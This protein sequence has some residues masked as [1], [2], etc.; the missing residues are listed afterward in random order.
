VQRADKVLKAR[1]ELQERIKSIRNLVS[2]TTKSANERS[3][4]A[5]VEQ[6][7]AKHSISP[8]RRSLSPQQSPQERH[9]SIPPEPPQ[10][11]NM[12]HVDDRPISLPSEYIKARA[13]VSAA[14]SRLPGP[15]EHATADA[16]PRTPTT[17]DVTPHTPTTGID[18]YDQFP[19]FVPRYGELTRLTC[20]SRCAW[21]SLD[22]AL[23]AI[24]NMSINNF[25]S[26]GMV[27]PEKSEIE[28]EVVGTEGFKEKLWR[29]K[30]QKE[31]LKARFFLDSFPPLDLVDVLAGPS[32]RRS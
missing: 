3:S 22:H 7:L 21:N 24:E 1:E 9:T 28:V 6:R 12:S 14:P 27:A 17:R 32:F 10:P 19:I 23:S 13:V 29:I 25:D 11:A 30:Q 8:S 20:D 2:S 26:L 31:A 4:P 5:A 18:R 15:Q 16:T